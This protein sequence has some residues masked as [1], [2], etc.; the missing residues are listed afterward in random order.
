MIFATSNVVSANSLISFP[1]SSKK[2]LRSSSN[3]VQC[4]CCNI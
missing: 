1:E 3:N 4:N 2:V